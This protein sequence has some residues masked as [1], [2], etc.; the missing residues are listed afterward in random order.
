MTFFFGGGREAFSINNLFD[1]PFQRKLSVCTATV[2]KIN[3]PFK[4]P[5][6][7]SG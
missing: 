1:N 4:A 2:G 5:F 6:L 3:D 7:E